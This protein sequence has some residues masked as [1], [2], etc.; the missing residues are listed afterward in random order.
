MH[1]S[2]CTGVEP[3][4]ARAI[5]IYGLKYEGIG[6]GLFYK[7]SFPTVHQPICFC[8]LENRPW[9]RSQDVSQGKPKYQV[10]RRVPRV[11]LHC[12]DWTEAGEEIF[13][14]DSALEKLLSCVHWRGLFE[15]EVLA[16]IMAL[17]PQVR[18]CPEM[19]GSCRIC[20]LPRLDETR[21]L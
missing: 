7:F 11:G 6:T 18:Q 10:L 9:R 12:M 17:W 2:H 16:M 13:P 20:L 15:K 3:K 19:K 1:C 8:S 4:P 14:S 5:P 21:A